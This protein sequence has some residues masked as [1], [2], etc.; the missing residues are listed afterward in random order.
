MIDLTGSDSTELDAM[1]K[2]GI[3]GHADGVHWW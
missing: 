3:E 2:P 1:F